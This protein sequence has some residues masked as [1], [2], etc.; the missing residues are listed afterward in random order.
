MRDLFHD[1]SADGDEED[2]QT[3]K[4][5]SSQSGHGRYPSTGYSGHSPQYS[6]SFSAVS[7]LPK[8][9]DDEKED[10]DVIESLEQGTTLVGSWYIIFL[11]A[12]FTLDFEQ[13]LLIRN[14]E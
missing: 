7:E 4:F 14:F 1:V 2:Q 10:E 8:S 12:R 9:L 6:E 3:F 11:S 5:E 13:K